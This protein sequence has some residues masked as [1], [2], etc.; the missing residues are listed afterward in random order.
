MAYGRT[1]RSQVKEAI[2]QLKKNETP[3][4]GAV[5]TFYDPKRSNS[6]GEYSYYSYY[7]SNYG[8]NK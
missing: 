7:S 8:D 3:I 1:R 4:I 2:M 5:F 6:Y